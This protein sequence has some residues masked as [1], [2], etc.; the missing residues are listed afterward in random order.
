MPYMGPK[1][2]GA[3]LWNSYVQ[4]AQLKM[5]RREAKQLEDLRKAQAELAQ[6]A[7]KLAERRQADDERRTDLDEQRLGET[8]AYNDER[9]GQM[10]TEEARAAEVFDIEKQDRATGIAEQQSA[11]QASIGASR[12]T[13]K[14]FF[15][16]YPELQG[17]IGAAQQF[18]Q[19]APGVP[20]L[21][22]NAKAYFLEGKT[23]EWGE[24]AEAIDTQRVLARSA[25]DT[26]IAAY[27]GTSDEGFEAG[28]QAII[29][30]MKLGQMTA[31]QGAKAHKGLILERATRMAEATRLTRGAEFFA[32][33]IDA[34]GIQPGSD[35]DAQA[36]ALQQL[37]LAR[38]IKFDEMN[39]GLM[40]IVAPPVAPKGASSGSAGAGNRDRID[41]WK[42]LM[43][44]AAETGEPADA[45]AM[46]AQAGE[47]LGSGGGEPPAQAQNQPAP[48][49][50]EQVEWGKANAAKLRGMT[51]EQRQAAWDS[52]NGGEAEPA[53][54]RERSFTEQ[55]E[56]VGMKAPTGGK[57]GVTP[58]TVSPEVQARIDR[59]AAEAKAKEKP[60]AQIAKTPAKYGRDPLTFDE[61]T[62]AKAASDRSGFTAKADKFFRAM[63]KDEMAEFRRLKSDASE[64][65]RAEFLSKMKAK[66]GRG[67]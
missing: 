31:E 51:P 32:A 16:K 12:G 17:E 15:D 8:E 39:K 63:S 59:M 14:S 18:L 65:E 66:Y 54:A 43:S 10:R 56:D 46:W 58:P 53:K 48:P 60:K 26:A 64:S 62:A 23:K 4:G 57:F 33:R 44:Q 41:M 7:Q 27:A 13:A 2:K 3:A 21:T 49:T 34:L 37:Y 1:D 50:S 30:K 25:D 55:A 42:A 47:M 36:Q 9:V 20:P 22:P 28:K 24:K 40:A 38:E 35:Q 5:A 52:R 6:R 19:G 11:T 61:Q 29:E 67:K 45:K